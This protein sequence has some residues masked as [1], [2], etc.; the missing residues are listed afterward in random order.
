MGLSATLKFPAPKFTKEEKG[1]GK[2]VYIVLL[3]NYVKFVW[4]FFVM[5]DFHKHKL[6][7]IFFQKCGWHKASFSSFWQ[8]V[9]LG[10]LTLKSTFNFFFTKRLLFSWNELFGYQ[11]HTQTGLECS[12]EDSSDS[13]FGY[14]PHFWPDPSDS[15]GGR[16]PDL[17]D[18]LGA[19]S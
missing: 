9:V 12:W 15:L 14:Q 6:H 5:W 11:P 10:F 8:N 4:I 2:D 1:L 19:K 7:R 16:K 13:L 3:F 18:S 17:S